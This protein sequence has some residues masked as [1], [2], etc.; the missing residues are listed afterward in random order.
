MWDLLNRN[1]IVLLKTPVDAVRTDW[2]SSYIDLEGFSGVTFDV[3]LGAF[4]GED[5][6]NYLTLSLYEYD[7]TGTPAPQTSGNYGAVAAAKLQGAFL[8]V[9]AAGRASKIQSVG[10]L[11][12]YRYLYL[13]GAYTSSGISAG[14]VGVVARLTPLSVPYE[15]TPTTGAV[16]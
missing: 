12:N 8:P 14:V 16:T 15:L 11:G 9:N 13:G 6:N 2:K 1:V 4:S 7:P 10:Y 3:I 5:T